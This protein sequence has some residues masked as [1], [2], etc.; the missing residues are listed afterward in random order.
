MSLLFSPAGE[1]GEVERMQKVPGKEMEREV[2]KKVGPFPH[3]IQAGSSLPLLP[4]IVAFTSRSR[5][6]PKYSIRE[7]G[8]LSTPISIHV[9]SIRT[10][11]A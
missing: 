4:L 6:S 2:M 8:A 3:F 10:I 11:G 5:L 7:S 1:A 9:W